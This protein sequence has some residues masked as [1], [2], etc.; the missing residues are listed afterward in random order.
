MK[1]YIM[2]APKLLYHLIF[3]LQGLLPGLTPWAEQL[4]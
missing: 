4:G 3:S 1:V 2:V